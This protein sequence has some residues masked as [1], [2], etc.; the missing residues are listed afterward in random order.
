MLIQGWKHFSQEPTHWTIS[1]QKP[2]L[3]LLLR[4]WY[5]IRCKILELSVT[6]NHLVPLP[7]QALNLLPWF[8]TPSVLQ[9]SYL[10]AHNWKC[11][12]YLSCFTTHQILR[13]PDSKNTS[14]SEGCPTKEGSHPK[15]RLPSYATLFEIPTLTPQM[16]SSNRYYL[17]V[18][19]TDTNA[20][21]IQG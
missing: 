12:C 18:R 11:P 1:Q 21:N 16:N 3:L 13:I 8:R 15:G 20:E 6:S 19:M 10:L 4:N 5:N 14:F 2:C 9:T 17:C 7:S